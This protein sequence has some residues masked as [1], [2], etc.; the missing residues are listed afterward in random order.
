MGVDLRCCS[1]IQVGSR[2][3]ATYI[4]VD[5]SDADS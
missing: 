1:P 2:R 3:G 4:L 5:I